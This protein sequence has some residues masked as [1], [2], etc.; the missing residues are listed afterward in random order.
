VT[1]TPISG[2]WDVRP[3]GG[4][5]PE[6]SPSDPTV[7]GAVARFALAGVIALAIVGLISVLVMRHVGTNEALSKA[8][9]VTRLVGKGIVEPNLTEGVVRGRPGAL[10]R[11]DQ[12]IRKRVLQNPIVRV[13][14]WEASGRL[15]YSDKRRLIGQHYH[16][17]ADELASLRDGSVE[18]DV[19]DL[20]RP[21][22]RF[23][24]GLGK[25]LEV[26]LPVK[27]PSGQPLLFEAYQS[28][29]SVTS[30]GRNLWLAF[31]PALVLA[32]VVLELVQLPL[33]SSMARRIRRASAEREAL[34]QRA[35]DSSIAERRRIAGDVHDGIVQDLAGLSFSLAAAAER[36][37]SDSAKSLRRG[38][39]QT[40]QS[41]R[42]L[43]SFLV[44]IYPPRLQEAG[45]KPALSDLLSPLAGRGIETSLDVPEGLD[46]QGDEEALMFRVAQEAVRNA[47]KHA[48][49]SRVDVRVSKSSDY[50]EL[51]V[52]DN[53]RGLPTELGANGAAE[54]HLGLR[55]LH[56][57]AASA[58]AALEIESE[59]GQGT[60][61]QLR[62]EQA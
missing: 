22:N 27:A 58:G 35:V 43:R 16:L 47:A 31:A 48:D 10:A 49:P 4:K 20:S 52:E 55:L 60:K 53:G 1:G 36:T 3:K 42:D 25:L 11:F 39:E 17:G 15:A 45:L 5:Q 7:A 21:E 12:L 9:E 26:Y 57:L 23:D 59:P 41:V 13:K 62:M 38:A 2:L 6:R 50:A 37:E 54:G 28:F 19:S 24:R 46:L 18:S 44:E 56:D 14:L 8:R 29:G 33:A 34:L 32:L 61:V 40:R 51:I 30:S